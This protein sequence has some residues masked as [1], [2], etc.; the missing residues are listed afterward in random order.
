[1]SEAFRDRRAA[2]PPQEPMK[3]SMAH[4]SRRFRIEARRQRRERVLRVALREWMDF[5]IRELFRPPPAI[6]PYERVPDGPAVPFIREGGTWEPL[7]QT[8][9]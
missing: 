2:V 1:M 8:E 5:R 6:P 4:G 3:R 7:A 9:S